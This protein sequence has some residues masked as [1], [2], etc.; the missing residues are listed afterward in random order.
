MFTCQAAH[1]SGFRIFLKCLIHF[2]FYSLQEKKNSR[3]KQLFFWIWFQN[4]QVCVI[5]NSERAVSSGAKAI[6]CSS[7][8]TT[9]SD[10]SSKNN[11]GCHA[12]VAPAS[13]VI[14]KYNKM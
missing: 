7:T 6:E 12:A 1:K 5:S 9:L 3:H 2:Q 13:E 8:L 10:T 14:L 4:T 11:K